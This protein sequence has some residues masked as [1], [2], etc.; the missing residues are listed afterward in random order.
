MRRLLIVLTLASVAISWLP[1]PGAAQSRQGD[2]REAQT[3]RISK[4]VNI[5]SNGEIE[6]TNISGDITITRGGNSS[7]TIE[8]EKSVRADTPEEARAL[9]ALVTVDVMERGTRAEV[10]ARYP[11]GERGGRRRQRGS[12]QVAYTVAAPQNTRIVARSISGSISVRDITGSLTL[13]SV[14][15]DIKLANAGRMTGAKTISGNVEMLDSRIEGTLEAGTISGTINLQRVTA[16]ALTLSSVSGD[17]VLEDLTCERVKGQSISGDTQFS[18]ELQ[19]NGR[20][21]FTSH[22]GS[23]RLA[24]AGKTGFQI[25]ATSFS[26]EIKTDIPL[27]LEGTTNA[28]RRGRAVRGKFGDGSA[29]VDLTSFSGSIL[30]SKR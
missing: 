3:E 1:A 23:V 14:S 25:E 7:A 27:T 29:F 16:Q 6:L 21:E 12:V 17:V 5:G 24:V 22:S 13:E 30:L 2:A 8:I 11:A 26:G 10:R 15:G 18:G 20:Y 4:T 19:P 9:L 28:N